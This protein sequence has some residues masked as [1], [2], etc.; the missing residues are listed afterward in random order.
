MGAHANL[1]LLLDIRAHM[2]I[3]FV[4]LVRDRNTVS[5]TKHDIY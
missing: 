1:H 3:V 4:S 2:I 5:S